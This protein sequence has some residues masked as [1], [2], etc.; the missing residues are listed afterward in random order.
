MQDTG[1]IILA[2]GSSSRLGIAKQLLDYQHK[3]LVKHAV[4]QA[5]AS[6]PACVIVVVG[7]DAEAVAGTLLDN[8]VTICYNEDWSTGMA[9]SI[10]KGMETLLKDH[11]L[12]TSCIFS[13]CDQPFLE[14]HH[15]TQLHEHQL[16]S[17]KG[18]VAS[19][20]ADTMGVPVLFSSF[21][22]S[23]LQQLQGDQGAK[24]I[25]AAYPDD[26]VAVAFDKGSIDIDEPAD[27]RYLIQEMVSVTEAK[28]IIKKHCHFVRTAI[29]ILPEALGYAVAE[30]IIAK[31][32]IPDFRQSSMDG[33]ALKF[34]DRNNRLEIV[35]EMRAGKQSEITLASGQAMRVF[36]GAP[37]PEGADTV[38]MQERVNREGDWITIADEQ[39]TLGMHVREK[40]S[41]AAKGTLALAQG[42]V[43]T[44]AA[45]GFLAGIGCEKVL[46]FEPPKVA[47]IITGDELQEL[48]QPLSFGQVYE[49]NSIQLCAALQ[50]SGIE[51]IKVFHAAD[52]PAALEKI[53]GQALLASDLVLLVGGVSVG[54]YDFV[55]QSALA[56]SV[57]PH[58]HKVKQKPGKPLFFGTQDE[59]VVFGL[60]GNPSSALTCFYLYV[61]SAID[62]MMQ[63]P[64]SI[65]YSQAVTTVDYAKNSG[66]THFIKAHLTDGKVL[67]LHAQESYRL[68]SYAQA[69]C[70][71]VIPE[72]S[73]GILTGEEVQVIVLP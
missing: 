57:R 48:G 32:D 19:A 40:G 5:L 53:L 4:E 71:L 13:V 66:L 25:I 63:R 73:T 6:G 46:I 41:E 36:T 52:D 2:A 15:F 43:L 22:F 18:I 59:T 44:P 56:Q 62:R 38:V 39:V 24:K 35:G 33:Y 67:P 14:S 54:D 3:P 23:L 11:P 55:V 29:K 50:K 28:A 51:T 31:Y 60:P 30:E 58:F 7:A 9:S 65:S 47:I 8:D 68:Q 34:E 21:Y 27:L 37:I 72:E 26:V 45:L 17:H 61:L 20:Y 16:E 49:S 1:I 70:L 12:L 69:N 42:T 10:R 64:D